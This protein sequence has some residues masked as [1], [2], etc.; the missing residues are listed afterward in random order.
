[1]PETEASLEQSET[2]DESRA[3]PRYESA[4]PAVITLLASGES[5]QANLVD[6]SKT[7]IRVC[8]WTPIREKTKL[9]FRFGKLIGY[10]EVRWCRPLKGSHFEIGI[11]VGHT[12]AREL[13]EAIDQAG[14]A[15]TGGDLT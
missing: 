3:E 13:V 1:M 5:F 10:G 15:A 9:R 12:L 11:Q 2:A 14:N 7:G 6:V 4:D 8:L